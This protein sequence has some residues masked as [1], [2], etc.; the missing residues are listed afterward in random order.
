M[1][2]DDFPPGREDAK[3][4]E[5]ARAFGRPLSSE[6]RWLRGGLAV[7]I[8]IFLGFLGLFPGTGS[9]H[10]LFPCAFRAITGLPCLFCGGTRATRAI[11]H[12]NFQTALSLNA[13]AFPALLFL[14]LAIV[15]LLAEALRGHR[16]ALWESAFRHLNK[17]APLVIALALAW[18]IFHLVSA[19]K[20]PKPELVDF[21][22]PIA[23]KAASLFK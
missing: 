4:L 16:L 2:A 18:W 22:N 5:V 9:L 20:T 23:A 7:A 19:L 17:L 21:N 13:V 8:V 10:P 12:G 6:G 3:V 14:V 1:L 15:V 11:L